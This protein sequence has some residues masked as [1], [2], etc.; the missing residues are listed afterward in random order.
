MLSFLGRI[1]EFIAARMK[2]KSLKNEDLFD[3]PEKRFKKNFIFIKF[4]TMQNYA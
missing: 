1:G 2:K 4:S 3:L